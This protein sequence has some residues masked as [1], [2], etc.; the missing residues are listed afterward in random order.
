MGNKFLKKLQNQPKSKS[1][2]IMNM[3]KSMQIHNFTILELLIVIS[4]IIILAALLL[5]ALNSAKMKAQAISCTSKMKQLGLLFQEYSNDFNG[6]LL[7]Q[8]C[9]V[10]ESDSIP[11]FEFS[12]PQGYF[13]NNYIMKNARTRKINRNGQS[14]FELNV[15][16]SLLSCPS[17]ILDSR[18]SDLDNRM[19]YVKNDTWV[20]LNQ[21][22]VIPYTAGTIYS[23]TASEMTNYPVILQTQLKQ[24]SRFPHLYE[25]R[26]TVGLT[27]SDPRFLQPMYTDNRVH[28]RHNRSANVLYA[29]G[30]V[31]SKRLCGVLKDGSYGN[32]ARAYEAE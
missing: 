28:Y 25:S 2:R 9:K 5:P 19:N 24:P 23:S 30:H 27:N 11:Y 22:Y 32:W 10:L 29:D 15:R 21:S 14:V 4:I 8:S 17:V 26:N 16:P 12:A 18:P 20:A 1:R 3:K 13:A 7:R 31:N 6:I